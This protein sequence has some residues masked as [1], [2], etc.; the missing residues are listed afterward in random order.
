M[1]KRSWLNQRL[2]KRRVISAAVSLKNKKKRVKENILLTCVVFWVCFSI[3][4][5]VCIWF[6]LCHP[7]EQYHN[8]SRRLEFNY[9]GAKKRVSGFQAY[10]HLALRFGGLKI[11]STHRKKYISDTMQNRQS[12]KRL[13]LWLIRVNFLSKYSLR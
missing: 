10:Q 7:G 2:S 3:V 8:M 1:G 5:C 6:I 9:K 12:H 11:N 13:P 4:I